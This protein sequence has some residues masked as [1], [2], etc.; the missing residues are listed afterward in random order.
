MRLLIAIILLGSISQ[1]YDKAECKRDLVQTNSTQGFP[2][3]RGEFTF[4]KLS[5]GKY[6]TLDVSVDGFDKD[7]LSV[8]DKKITQQIFHEYVVN[9]LC[10]NSFDWKYTDTV[11]VN[12]RS[13][14]G[15]KLAKIDITRQECSVKQSIKHQTASN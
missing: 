7:N 15:Q 14:K 4:N 6:P 3:K 9:K 5:C 12:F 13:N 2:F 10:V 8:N 11:R 1:A